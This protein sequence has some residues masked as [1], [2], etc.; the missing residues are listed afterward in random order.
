MK[1]K[2]YE[3]LYGIEKAE[4]LK[5]SRSIIGKKNR[6]LYTIYDK[7]NKI[8]YSGKREGLKNACLKHNIKPTPLYNNKK[9]KEYVLVVNQDNIQ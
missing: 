2:T 9:Y 7:N 5:K 4:D 1:G 6:R 3:E 8:L